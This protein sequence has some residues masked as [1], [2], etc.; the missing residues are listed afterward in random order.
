MQYPYS[1]V[2]VF[3]ERAFSGAQITVFTQADGLTEGQMQMLARETN[4]SETVFVMPSAADCAARLRV[5]SPL[6]E[7]AAGSH[8]TVAAAF[9]LAESGGIA[10]GT[11][12]SKCEFVQG[13][14][15]L[16]ILFN[17]SDKSL[18]TQVGF[19][20]TPQIDRYVPA[21]Q[22]LLGI[23]GLESQDLETLKA[24]A[25]FVS[26]G[27]PYLIVPLRSLDAVYRAAFHAEAWAQ[28]SASS[29]P[30]SEILVYCSETENPEADFHLRLLGAGRSPHDDPPVGAA[31]PAFVAFLGEKLAQGTH[32][33]WVERGTKR[34]RQS[35]LKVEFETCA[36]APLNVRVGGEAVLVAQ[37]Q[38]RAP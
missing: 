13:E 14:Q 35:L 17:R 28:S 27:S 8:T 16:P 31:V 2:D 6:G 18:L 20:V 7:R 26:C 24:R 21:Q 32:T 34:T 36:S 37:G 29:V 19:T 5:Y 38:M 33:L 23:L 15:R 25:L 12:L 10:V 11:G 22:E 30:V 3:T 4:H 9:A 1:V